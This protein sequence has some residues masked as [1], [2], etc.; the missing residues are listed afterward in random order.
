VKRD[1]SRAKT[2]DLPDTE[3]LWI[4]DSGA[5]PF[6]ALCPR[7]PKNLVAAKLH[8]LESR[9]W[10]KRTE[11]LYCVTKAGKEAMSA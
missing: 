3:V 8:K 6:E 7:W 10:L 4:V 5:W 1:P 2:S 9:G 11:S